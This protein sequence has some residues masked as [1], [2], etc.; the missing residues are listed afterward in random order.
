[1]IAAAA[2]AAAFAPARAA[3]LYYALSYTLML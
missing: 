3:I 2:A 1:M